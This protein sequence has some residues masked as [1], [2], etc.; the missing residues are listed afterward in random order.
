MGVSEYYHVIRTRCGRVLAKSSDIN[1]W[2]LRRCRDR[3]KVQAGNDANDNI[4]FQSGFN[5]PPKLD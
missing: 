2:P 5:P 3:T 1:Y 4:P